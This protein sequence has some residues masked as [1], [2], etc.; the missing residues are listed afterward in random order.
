VGDDI[1]I[2]NETFLMTD[3]MNLKINLTPSFEVFIEIRYVCV[4]IKLNAQIMF[5]VVS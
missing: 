1:P 4:F 5:L 3:F 2:D